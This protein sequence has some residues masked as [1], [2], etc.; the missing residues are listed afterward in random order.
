MLWSSAEAA[1]GIDSSQGGRWQAFT[2]R[3]PAAVPKRRPVLLRLM[4]APT[5]PREANGRLMRR[6]QEGAA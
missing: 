5:L 6:R 1:E 2:R 3:L 4:H